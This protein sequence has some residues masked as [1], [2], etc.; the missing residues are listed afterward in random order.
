MRRIREPI[1]SLLFACPR[2]FPDFFTVRV[3]T[4]YFGL[5]PRSNL[6]DHCTPIMIAS[7][8]VQPFAALWT[9]LNEK[10]NTLQKL[11]MQKELQEA[12]IKCKQADLDKSA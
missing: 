7:S 5:S 12:E 9:H 1:L 4:R 10:Q 3:N 8:I 2:V 6:I 11:A